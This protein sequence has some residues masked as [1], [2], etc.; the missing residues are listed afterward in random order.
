MVSFIGNALRSAPGET[1]K[2]SGSKTT[3]LVRKRQKGILLDLFTL[4]LFRE[5]LHNFSILEAFGQTFDVCRTI[6]K[7][8]ASM[9]RD[10][11]DK[12]RQ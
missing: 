8:F 4:A 2:R 3:P 10:V 1:S 5:K 9:N 7:L 6:A 11:Y 12:E